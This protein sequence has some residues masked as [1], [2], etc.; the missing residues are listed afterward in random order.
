MKKKDDLTEIDAFINLNSKGKKVRT[1]LAVALKN[2]K[3]KTY[4]KNNEKMLVSEE[5]MQAIS[6]DVAKAMSADPKSAW[7]G[8]II[9]ADEIGKRNEQPIS[10]IAF[11]RSIVPII[12]KYFKIQTIDALSREQYDCTVDH[13]REVVEKAWNIVIEQWPNCFEENTDTTVS[14]IFVKGLA[15][16]LY[17]GCFLTVMTITKRDI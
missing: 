3:T 13:I 7:N 6:M 16:I 12:E 14:I 11:S 15:L 1:D 2:K 17:L 9:Q 4:M 8:L 10:I 5:I